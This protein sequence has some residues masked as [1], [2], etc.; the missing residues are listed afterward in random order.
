MK[1]IDSCHFYQ[2]TTI[3]KQLMNKKSHINNGP[4]RETL[5]LVFAN[6][7]GADQHAHPRRLISAFIMRFFLG[8]IIYIHVHTTGEF[9]FL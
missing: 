2:S 1:Q 5:L 4:T 9:S 6:N 7:K 3:Y 8:I